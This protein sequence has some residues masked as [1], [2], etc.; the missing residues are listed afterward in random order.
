MHTYRDWSW[1]KWDSR[2]ITG[3][4]TSKS[5]M[6]GSIVA[7]F[8]RVTSCYSVQVLF[9]KFHGC[10]TTSTRLLMTEHGKMGKKC[11]I[12]TYSPCFLYNYFPYMI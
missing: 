3:C 8:H 4:V 9:N 10:E 1:K 6:G 2:P 5:C 12:K 7:Q 11:F